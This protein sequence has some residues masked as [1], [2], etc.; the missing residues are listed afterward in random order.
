M[1]APPPEPD[2]G[3]LVRLA[4]ELLAVALRHPD[5]A[6]QLMGTAHLLLELANRKGSEPAVAPA[7]SV[8]IDQPPVQEK[9]ATYAL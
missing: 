1:P 9:A 4:R 3:V 7:G 5:A 2:D 6:S 8:Q